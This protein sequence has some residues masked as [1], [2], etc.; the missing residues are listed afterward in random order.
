MDTLN[1]TK[2]EVLARVPFGQKWMQFNTLKIVET[3]SN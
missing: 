3:V 1:V 2:D